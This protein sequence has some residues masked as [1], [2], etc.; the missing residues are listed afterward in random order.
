M[1]RQECQ[2]QHPLEQRDTVL[3]LELALLET[4]DE[5]LVGRRV[6]HEV[7]DDQIEVTMLH[8]QF[9]QLLADGG[10]FLVVV[11]I[12]VGGTGWLRAMVVPA[13]WKHNAER[14]RVDDVPVCR[15]CYILRA[16]KGLE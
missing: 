9:I 12:H 3:Q 10:E 8:L 14:P 13:Q 11:R 16:A 2:D 4:A 5:Q 15:P 7:L 1:I 6:E